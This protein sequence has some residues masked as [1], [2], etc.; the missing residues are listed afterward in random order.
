MVVLNSWFDNFIIS[1][2]SG[3]IQTLFLST[4]FV[5]FCLLMY[6]V[7]LLLFKAGRGVLSK[8]N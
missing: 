7:F 6:L 5:C 4:V 8:R 3:L 2:K 1:S